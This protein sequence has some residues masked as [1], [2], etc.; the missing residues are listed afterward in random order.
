MTSNL[1]ISVYEVVGSP[2]CV[3]SGDGQK[4]HDR[5]F[6]ALVQGQPVSLSFRNV[7]TLTSAFLNAAIGQL[8]GR[9]KEAEIRALLSVE[10]MDP[11]DAAL[12]RRVVD[13]AK[14][15]F[16]DPERFE[17][18]MREILEEDSDDDDA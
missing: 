4:L 18:T 14:H 1:T 8:Y 2:L 7:S 6:T 12:L 5:L 13:T 9:L 15:Y 16:S 17:S 10:D 3:A 11:D